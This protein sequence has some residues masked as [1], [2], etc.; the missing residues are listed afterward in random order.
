MND[1]QTLL[2]HLRQPEYIHVIINHLPIFG[3]A[4]AALALGLG[5]LIRNRPSQ[6]VALLLIA[7][8]GGSTWFVIRS[9][10]K[11]YDRVYAMSNEDA[12]QWLQVHAH[13]AGQLAFLFYGTA[14]LAIAAALADKKSEKA[15]RLL[16][17]FALLA[18]LASVNAA[19][20]ISEAG[21]QV[22][23]SEFREGPPR[24]DQLPKEEHHHH[25]D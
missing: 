3:M 9:G 24:P 11:G 19:G 23:H 21:G 7:L 20:W 18:A 15:A 4:T 6:Q 22:R 17:W 5:L 16:T 2:I 13:R 1:I 25:D 14:L 8:M 12:Q 10:H